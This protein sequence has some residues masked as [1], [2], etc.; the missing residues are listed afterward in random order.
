MVS[1][2]ST[3]INLTLIVDDAKV[4]PVMRLLHQ[5]FFGGAAV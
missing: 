1:L 4:H 3:G 2:S 5:E